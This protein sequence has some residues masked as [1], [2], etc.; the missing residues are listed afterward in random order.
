MTNQSRTS[1]PRAVAA[2][3]LI[4]V[5]WGTGAVMVLGL[6]VRPSSM[7]RTLDGGAPVWPFQ[8]LVV[9]VLTGIGVLGL[10]VWRRR[11]AVERVPPPPGWDPPASGSGWF[12]PA[13]IALMGVGVILVGSSVLPFLSRDLAW[14]LE[15]DRSGVTR[16]RVNAVVV[17]GTGVLGLVISASG[18]AL[19]R[20]RRPRR[21]RAPRYRHRPDP[22]DGRTR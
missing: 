2:V 15:V 17:V 7:A 20:A 19:L 12:A 18:L 22:H 9:A 10:L 14:F 5:G 4:A 11:S 21:V 3:V 16:D 13:G 6:A 1:V 8:L